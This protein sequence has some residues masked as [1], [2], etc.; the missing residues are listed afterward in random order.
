MK[1]VRS[2]VALVIAGVAAAFG[3]HYISSYSLDRRVDQQEVEI[4]RVS[5]QAEEQSRDLA[6]QGALLRSAE[7][8][9]RQH[10]EEINALQIRLGETEAKI[11]VT[12]EEIRTL[13][14]SS[15]EDRERLV[16]L[17]HTLAR[18]R[19]DQEKRARALKELRKQQLQRAEAF[20]RRLQEIEKR[21]GV[22][23]GAEV[24]N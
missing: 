20:D 22:S 16:K 18:L 9:L 2:V 13:R 12:E 5:R 19:D 6:N 14:V 21:I 23:P 1:I 17:E 10:S 3:Y 11:G 4:D 24:E 7:K 8:G 15:G